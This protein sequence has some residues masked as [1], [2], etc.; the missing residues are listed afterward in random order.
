MTLHRSSWI[1]FQCGFQIQYGKMHKATYL[2][3]SFFFFL[4]YETMHTPCCDTKLEI[5]VSVH[6]WVISFLSCWL[7]S[8]LLY[9]SVSRKNGAP[10]SITLSP[11]SWPS[12][13]ATL[14]EMIKEGAKFHRCSQAYSGKAR[15]VSL[16]KLLF[17]S[18]LPSFPLRIC[19]EQES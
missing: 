1:Y 13:L 11:S 4:P 16:G 7:S 5:R 3:S 9:C 18:V 10:C 14:L 17:T 8:L 6:C 12:D 2:L 15:F 19:S